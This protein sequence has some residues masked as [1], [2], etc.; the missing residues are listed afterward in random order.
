MKPKN[1]KQNKSEMATPRKPS[2]LLLACPRRAIP[3]T[4]ATKSITMSVPYQEA[5]S[6]RA[7]PFM[8]WVLSPFLLLFAAVFCIPLKESLDV[9][10]L[11]PVVVTSLLIVLCLAG[12]MALWGVPFVGRIASGIIAIAFGWY[13]VD[14]CVINFNGDWG[15][16]KK[17]SE[18]T[19][20][21]SICGFI[22]F[23]VPCLIYTIFGRFTLRKEPDF[24]ENSEYSDYDDFDDDEP[25]QT[26]KAEQGGDGDAEEAV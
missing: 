5:F 23:G 10:D 19:P 16:D 26:K 8:R 11:V 21:N 2:D 24:D 25:H 13:L 3:I 20:F 14:Q 7:S 22:V 6:R 12:F 4:F 15:F 18:A 17:R 9:A 1:K